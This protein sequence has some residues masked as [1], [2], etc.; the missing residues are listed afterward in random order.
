MKNDW[1]ITGLAVKIKKAL[2]KDAVILWSHDDELPNDLVFGDVVR[3]QALMLDCII[4]YAGLGSVE[5][6]YITVS[7]DPSPVWTAYVLLVFQLFKCNADTLPSQ[8]REHLMLIKND[9]E[10]V[11]DG[12][13]LPE[14]SEF[15]ERNE[16]IR[17]MQ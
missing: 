8:M 2:E 5:V 10:L 12:I 15:D 9:I 14:L 6:G 17:T 7:R 16:K 4:L 13:V 1:E 3:L 11:S